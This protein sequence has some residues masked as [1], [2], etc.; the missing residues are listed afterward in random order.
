M[1]VSL[2]T[3]M[4]ENLVMSDS[5]EARSHPVSLELIRSKCPL[6]ISASA[7]PTAVA[8]RLASAGF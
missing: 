1:T 6:I 3:V 7:G 4:P 2:P 8:F 5:L